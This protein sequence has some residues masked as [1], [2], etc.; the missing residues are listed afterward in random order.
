MW[1]CHKFSQGR[2]GSV[3]PQK[4]NFVNSVYRENSP[5][6]RSKRRQRLRAKLKLGCLAAALGYAFAGFTGSGSASAATEYNCALHNK[7][8]QRQSR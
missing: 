6:V 3:S 4:F 8:A 5:N 2:L 1:E 7:T